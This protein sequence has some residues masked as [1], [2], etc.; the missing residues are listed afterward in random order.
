MSIK[1]S[2][3]SDIYKSSS[4]SLLMEINLRQLSHSV[5]AFEMCSGETRPP[6]SR[7]HY[8]AGD[9]HRPVLPTELLVTPAGQP[10]HFRQKTTHSPA[11]LNKIKTFQRP[12]P[13][14]TPSRAVFTTLGATDS[15][16]DLFRRCLDN[17]RVKSS[18]CVHPFSHLHS[19][20]DHRYTA[21]LPPRSST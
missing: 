14:N 4:L 15:L 3:R 9:H 5:F 6:Q 21:P 10:A 19:C 11:D 18:F 17:L 13:V 2:V 7:E 8:G 16:I 12:S 1:N 20:E